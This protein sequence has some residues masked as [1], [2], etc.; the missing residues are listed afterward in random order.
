V[1]EGGESGDSAGKGELGLTPEAA[2]RRSNT[3]SDAAPPFTAPKT[4]L[5]RRVCERRKSTGKEKL[6]GK[7]KNTVSHRRFSPSRRRG[8]SMRAAR[9]RPPAR[10]CAGRREEEL[11]P[12][13]GRKNSRRSLG[14]RSSSPGGS[15]RQRQEQEAAP[16]SRSLVDAHGGLMPS[17]RGGFGEE[18]WGNL[19]EVV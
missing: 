16:R 3:R 1:R 14:G 7:R 19:E 4:D 9:G 10:A 5:R 11:A 12:V 15:A 18:I 17:P 13:T 6:P 8:G 2:P